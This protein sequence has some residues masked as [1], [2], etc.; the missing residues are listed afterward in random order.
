MNCDMF[1][2]LLP[3][4]ETIGRIPTGDLWIFPSLAGRTLLGGSKRHIFV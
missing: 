1:S 4:E 2:V 3:H